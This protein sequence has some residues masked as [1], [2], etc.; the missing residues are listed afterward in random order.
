MAHAFFGT[1]GEQIW[2]GLDMYRS[3]SFSLETLALCL[4]LSLGATAFWGEH[5]RENFAIML[6]M[7]IFLTLLPKKQDEP[8]M[9]KTWRHVPTP[10]QWG[11]TVFQCLGLADWKDDL[12][13][14]FLFSK[15]AN[16]LPALSLS[17]RPLVCLTHILNCFHLCWARFLPCGLWM[18]IWYLQVHNQMSLLHS[19]ALWGETVLVCLV[20]CLQC[21]GESGRVIFWLGSYLF[22][23]SLCHICFAIAFLA[24]LPL[25]QHV[26]QWKCW[27][28]LK[29]WR[30]LLLMNILSH[31]WLSVSTSLIMFLL[32]ELIRAGVTHSSMGLGWPL[33]LY[34]CKEVYHAIEPALSHE[35]LWKC[36]GRRSGSYCSCEQSRSYQATSGMNLC[37]VYLKHVLVLPLWAMQKEN[38]SF[39]FSIPCWTGYWFCFWVFCLLYPDFIL[40]FIFIVQQSPSSSSS[41]D[42]W[43]SGLCYASFLPL[44]WNIKSQGEAE[45]KR[46]DGTRP[47]PVYSH[48]YLFLLIFPSSGTSSIGWKTAVVYSWK[49]YIGSGKMTCFEK[50]SM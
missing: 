50:L 17:F 12:C 44:I 36:S 34:L 24:F 26:L 43:N 25:F 30:C 9:V 5:Q 22:L 21:L 32:P 20:L 41:P 46:L 18:T 15:R 37:L 48:F 35:E 28:I 45:V 14:V 27:H 8:G 31:F 39:F 7:K 3:W 47:L 6:S 29:M 4:F 11:K 40:L 1:V 33:G 2:A 19:A 16:P 38:F 10:P 23:L 42:V 49:F 13:F